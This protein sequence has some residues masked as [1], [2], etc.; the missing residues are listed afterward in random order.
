VEGCE[1]NS[2]GTLSL[3]G[4]YAQAPGLQAVAKGR[5]SEGAVLLVYTVMCLSGKLQSC[6]CLCLQ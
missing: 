1:G 2:W 5:G 3:R 4:V 6:D